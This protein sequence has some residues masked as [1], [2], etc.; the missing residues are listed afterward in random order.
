MPC[1]RRRSRD[2]ARTASP[3]RGP[4]R[5]LTRESSGGAPPALPSPDSNGQGGCGERPPVPLS[6][7]NRK[8]SCL[9]RERPMRRGVLVAALSLAAPL[10]GLLSSTVPAAQAR[11]SGQPAALLAVLRVN[12]QGWLPGET[13]QV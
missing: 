1:S 9:T 11:P 8:V 7:I 5:S 13:K 10:L 6:P 3:S 4:R 2:V 12:Q